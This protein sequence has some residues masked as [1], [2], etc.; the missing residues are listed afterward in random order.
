MLVMLEA[1]WPSLKT[2]HNA[3]P[4]KIGVTSNKLIAY[5]V[6]WARRF[7][8]NHPLIHRLTR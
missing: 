1:I 4:T 8:F 6:F 2:Y 3:I 5:F 7:L